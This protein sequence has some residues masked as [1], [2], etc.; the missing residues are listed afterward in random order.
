MKFG[1]FILWYANFKIKISMARKEKSVS[2]I[3]ILLDI[4]EPINES[5]LFS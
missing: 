2:S 4:S 3:L 5:F 1:K